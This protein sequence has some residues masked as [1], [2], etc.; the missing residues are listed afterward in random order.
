[1]RKDTS[2]IQVMVESPFFSTE[3]GMSPITTGF[4]YC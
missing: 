4:S 1:M 3:S 2:Y